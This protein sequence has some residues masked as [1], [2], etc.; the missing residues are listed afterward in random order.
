MLINAQ[1]E[2]NTCEKYNFNGKKGMINLELTSF[3]IVF[4]F[5]CSY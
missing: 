4:Y 1:N 3:F 5:N 2:T